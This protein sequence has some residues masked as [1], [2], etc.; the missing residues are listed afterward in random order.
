MLTFK[1][2]QLMPR[3]DFAVSKINPNP[4][5]HLVM[6]TLKYRGMVLD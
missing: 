3:I 5:E 6:R 1:E 2:M 4:Q